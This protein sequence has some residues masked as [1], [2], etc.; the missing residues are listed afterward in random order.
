MTGILQQGFTN[1]KLALA[2]LAKREWLY[3][4]SLFLLQRVLLSG[5]GV[6]AYRLGIVP[7]SEHP[8]LRPYFGVA[9]VTKGLSG[10]LLG[11]WQRFDVVHFIRIARDGYADADLAPFFPLYPL[12]TRWVGN[13]FSG[14]FL[15]GSFLVA[16][17]SCLLLLIAFYQWMLYE[18]HKQEIARRA[19]LFLVWFPTSFFLFVPYSESLFLLLAILAFWGIRRRK[20]A[21]GG[22]AALLATLTRIGGI[23]MS[24]I[25]LIELYNNRHTLSRR[26][27]IL[28]GLSSLLPAFGFIGLIVWRSSQQLPN[29]IEVQET[30]WHRLPAWPWEG[31]LATVQ[32]LIDQNA[33]GIELL[34]LLVLLG[35]VLAGIWM[36]KTLPLSFSIYHWGLLLLGLAQIRL[37]QPLSGQAR[38]AISL[39]PAFIVLAK[40]ATGPISRRLVAYGFLPFHLFFAGQFILWGW[41]G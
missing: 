12:L 19:L 9:P 10:I 37:G 25:I 40:Y 41:V 21:L 34:D 13:L 36:I 6:A 24:P 20:W 15:L 38:F 29:L 17:I 32:R 3:P 28:G 27:Q 22:V 8:V 35:M 26:E 11:V 18:G 33:Y 23:I 2:R 5:L 7:L 1:A 14:D 39:F 30:Y 31:V 16:N 4:L